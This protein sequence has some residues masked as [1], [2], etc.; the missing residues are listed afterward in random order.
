MKIFM[1]RKK[2]EI[3]IFMKQQGVIKTFK[4]GSVG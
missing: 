3:V 1:V 2:F 4:L